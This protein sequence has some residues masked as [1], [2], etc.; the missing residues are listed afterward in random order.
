MTTVALVSNPV[1]PTYL[2]ITHPQTGRFVAEFDP[3]R[4]L[5]LVVDHGHIAVI[6]LARIR[7]ETNRNEPIDNNTT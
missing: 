1:R 3:A 7:H 6:D 5:L 4:D 2:R